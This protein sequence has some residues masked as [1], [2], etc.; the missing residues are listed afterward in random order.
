MNQILPYFLYFLGVSF[1]PVIFS[2][3]YLIYK[4]AQNKGNLKA[5]F[6]IADYKMA[7]L[8]LGERRFTVSAIS[9]YW[10][11]YS[12]FFKVLRWFINLAFSVVDGKNHCQ[13]HYYLE[14]RVFSVEPKNKKG[15]KRWLMFWVAIT[16]CI[17]AYLVFG[18]PRLFKPK[19]DLMRSVI[20]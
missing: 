13:Y 7:Y 2:A 18:L 4:M 15:P 14:S 8:L 1:I 12:K 6:A 20:L 5:S 11:D 10:G 3:I 19:R 16:T 9:G 17:A